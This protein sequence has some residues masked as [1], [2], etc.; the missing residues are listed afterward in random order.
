MLNLNMWFD[1]VDLFVL[2]SLH[3]LLTRASVSRCL[4]P[5][6]NI[7][8][9]LLV[10]TGISHF[11]QVTPN[12]VTGDITSQSWLLVSVSRVESICDSFY[13]LSQTW[14]GWLLSGIL[15][16]RS[17][18]CSPSFVH[19]VGSCRPPPNCDVGCVPPVA[20]REFIPSV[21]SICNSSYSL[22]QTWSGFTTCYFLQSL[23]TV[24]S[25]RPHNC[26]VGC[27]ALVEAIRTMTGVDL[28]GK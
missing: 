7:T 5:P 10:C 6:N 12:F 1:F 23:E 2:P 28:F 11:I 3:H 14:R 22:S 20:A 19:S 16:T 26:D 18:N 9:F 17:T 15:M 4:L 13:A 24:G 8:V 25:R 21:E 27:Y